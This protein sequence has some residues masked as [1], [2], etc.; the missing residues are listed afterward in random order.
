MPASGKDPEGWSAIDKFTLVLDTTGFNTTEL[1]AY[2]RALCLLPEQVERRHQ[3]ASRSAL[4]QL[5]CAQFKQ[6]LRR[7]EKALMAAAEQL[8]VAKKIQACWREDGDGRTDSC[9]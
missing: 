2:C 6:E 7:K 3:A 1:N 9:S 4:G 5:D 8:I